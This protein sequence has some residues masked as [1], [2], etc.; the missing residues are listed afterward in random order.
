[1]DIDILFTEAFGVYHTMEDST[2]S[3]E[4]ARF[5]RTVMF[6]ETGLLSDLH[7][8]YF[9]LQSLAMVYRWNERPI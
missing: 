4:W 1:M 5:V 8:I 2:A 6:A 7:C 3:D 9:A